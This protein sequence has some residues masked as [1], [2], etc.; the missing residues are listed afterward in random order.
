MILLDKKRRT[1]KLQQGGHV[2]LVAGVE[3]EYV[4]HEYATPGF[5]H[6][7]KPMPESRRPIGSGTGG[8]RSRYGAS[9]DLKLGAGG[10]KADKDYLNMQRNT[11]HSEMA[12]KTVNQ[13][14]YINSKEWIMDYRQGQ[15]YDR[16]LAGL[17][18]MKAGFTEGIPGDIDKSEYAMEQGYAFVVNRNT[19]QKEVK[20]IYS[21]LR[22]PDDYQILSVG[23]AYS[24]RSNEYLFTGFLEPGQA[25]ENIIRSAP[26][27]GELDKVLN[28]AIKTAGMSITDVETL[29]TPQGDKVKLTNLLDYMAERNN[30]ELTGEL[31]EQFRNNHKA[32]ESAYEYLAKTVLAKPSLKRAYRNLSVGSLLA[33]GEDLSG[34][35]Q[36]EIEEVISGEMMSNLG[37]R[38]QIALKTTFSESYKDVKSRKTATAEDASKTTEHA[39]AWTL[40]MGM[41]ESF[42]GHEYSSHFDNRSNMMYAYVNTI[43][44]SDFLN[45]AWRREADG[46]VP[47]N[48]YNIETLIPGGNMAESMKLYDTD[49]KLADLHD[50][51]GLEN[52]I[53]PQT[54]KVSILH[55]VP[56]E[57]NPDNGT[58]EISDTH[59]EMMGNF[60][61][62]V[63]AVVE[64]T[65]KKLE[66]DPYSKIP[67]DL[68]QITEN[69][70]WKD[71]VAEGGAFAEFAR[72]IEAGQ[73][74]LRDLGMMEMY[75]PEVRTWMQWRW[76]VDSDPYEDLLEELTTDE[77]K[78]WSRLLND[79]EIADKGIFS[80]VHKVL[81]TFPVLPQEEW[82]WKSWAGFKRE[83]FKQTELRR[84]FEQRTANE[85][86]RIIKRKNISENIKKNF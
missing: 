41:P 11:L 47:K 27:K 67:I 6:T 43:E 85:A 71:R 54:E 10:L 24:A 78:E 13:E 20:D 75:V 81:V 65:A 69:K 15:E 56:M 14:G 49:I 42:I 4:P 35:T 63:L 60:T 25:L 52:A 73:F 59:M 19:G 46:R 80:E 2:S 28:N 44:D 76:G 61:D 18:D 8:S 31:R 62:D 36:Q 53:I 70:L 17:K 34:K 39:Y 32:L 84:Y 3:E 51:A 77:R 22:A 23:D 79:S 58:W 30:F 57:Q 5:A 33:Q 12:W 68:L 45:K 83:P 50:G 7:I 72:G 66:A 40:N 55:N 38:L 16:Q 21:I 29:V 86:G 82:K 9:S 64:E 74:Q 48:N 26:I 37:S 1:K